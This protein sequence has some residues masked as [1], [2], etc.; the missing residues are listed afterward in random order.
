MRR[1]VAALVLVTAAVA[2]AGAGPVG[3]SA[4]STAAVAP[5]PHAVHTKPRTQPKTPPATHRVHRAS[6]HRHR[7]VSAQKLLT[8]AVAPLVSDDGDQVA[9]AVDDL[10]TGARATYGGNKHFITASIVKVD[11]LA[12][13]L[14][15]GQQTGQGLSSG[16]QEQATT[17]IE[18]S[19][20]DAATDLYNEAGGAGDISEA[21]QA[22]GLR[23]TTVGTDDY[24]GL[25]STT[26]DDQIR[27]LRSV[28]TRPSVLSPA[29]QR[30]LQDLM[31]RV[32]TDQQWGVPAAAGR[33]TRFMV[34]NGWLPNTT[35]WEI[36][37]I[38]E[39]E[40]GHQHL[41]IAVLSDGNASEYSGID[42]VEAVAKKAAAA[43]AA[44]DQTT[45][46]HTTTGH[47]TTG[48]TA[49]GKATSPSQIVA[50]R[51]K[52]PAPPQ[53]TPSEWPFTADQ[54]GA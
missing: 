41:L 24:W 15:Q 32:E 11:I 37:S 19:D 49:T 23:Q 51:R 20:D 22:F 13:L 45:T 54:A 28:F 2:V 17:M 21:N 40:R 18:D 30:Y 44:S 26:P 7:T 16:E 52:V 42:V 5:R 53:L 33:G 43:V 50:V 48:H 38:G 9:V 35:L 12:T 1:Y 10:T 6:T 39:I 47:T 34:K 8:A 3:K 36:N 29:S 27:L 25:T 4:A 31:S 14:Y 46:G